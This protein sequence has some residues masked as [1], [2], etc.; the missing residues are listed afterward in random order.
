MQMASAP[1]PE[2]LFELFTLSAV[3]ARGSVIRRLGPN[4]AHTHVRHWRSVAP[5]TQVKLSMHITG[6][7]GSGS[8]MFIAARTCA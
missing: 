4:P 8:R 5:L 1:F 7:A 2:E 6:F 3:T